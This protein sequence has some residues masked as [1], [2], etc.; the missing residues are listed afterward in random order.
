MSYPKIRSKS[1][2]YLLY[3]QNKNPLS[4]SETPNIMETI[5]D[6]Y[7][8]EYSYNLLVKNHIT[9]KNLM[10]NSSFRSPKNHPIS[11]NNISTQNNQ[12]HKKAKSYNSINYDDIYSH[13]N[14]EELQII[15]PTI[16]Y[17]KRNS[18]SKILSFKNN[19][20]KKILNNIHNNTIQNKS[21][22]EHSITTNNLEANI[23]KLNKESP[24][25]KEIKNKHKRY[26]SNNSL[27]I[28]NNNY[29][30]KKTKSLKKIIKLSDNSKTIPHY[31]EA[32]TERINNRKKQKFKINKNYHNYFLSS[33]GNKFNL[34]MHNY[35]SEN[36]ISTN[37]NSISDKRYPSNITFGNSL[38]ST[39]CQIKNNKFPQNFVYV[40]KNNKIK[41]NS[42]SNNIKVFEKK[43]HYNKFKTYLKNIK[44]NDSYDNKYIN[45]IDEKNKNEK[46]LK[47]DSRLSYIGKYKTFEEIK[48]KNEKMIIIKKITNNNL[49]IL[50]HNIDNKNNENKY[51]ISS[52][53]NEDNNLKTA[54]FAF[55]D[56]EK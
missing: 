17:K 39:K 41:N 32:N 7:N 35:N 30:R 53:H 43:T 36:S 38:M 28:D 44:I 51:Y 19:E 34:N 13:N 8:H 45:N 9:P 48:R 16:Y 12:A 3:I 46:E 25:N 50:T 10:N 26:N 1:I 40:K 23:K 4:L 6:N 22:R 27:I 37:A 56:N 20:S 52:N 42:L 31:E 14:Y 54:T 49:N 29:N 21:V 15:E 55:Y 2:N 5:K 47:K 24:Y 11:Q 18:I 33:R